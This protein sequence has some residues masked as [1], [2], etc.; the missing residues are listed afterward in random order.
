MTVRLQCCIQFLHER[1]HLWADR[2]LFQIKGIS[3]HFFENNKCPFLWWITK[4]ISFLT[5]IMVKLSLWIWIL[6]YSWKIVLL[7][8]IFNGSYISGEC[9]TY[10]SFC[11]NR[12]HFNH[13][14]QFSKT[15]STLISV[16]FVPLWWK[17]LLTQ[18]KWTLTPTQ[19]GQGCSRTRHSYLLLKNR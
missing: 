1:C 12:S 18:R 4:F 7:F 2:M 13:S 11:E 17:R 6:P 5:K 9:V 10:H 14:R 16:A 3:Q 8:D 15:S 19:P